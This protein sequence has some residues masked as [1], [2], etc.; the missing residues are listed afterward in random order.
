MVR[1]T[2]KDRKRRGVRAAQQ[3][4]TVAQVKSE[5]VPQASPA[6]DL[7]LPPVATGPPRAVPPPGQPPISPP[8]S[9]DPQLPPAPLSSEQEPV[10]PPAVAVGIPLPTA[11]SPAAG[12]TRLPAQTRSAA[13]CSATAPLP[14]DYHA[15]ATQDL[16]QRVVD[17]TRSASQRFYLVVLPEDGHPRLEQFTAVDP[18]LSRIQQLVAEAAEVSL[19]PFIG[20]FMPI[21]KGPNRFLKTPYGPLPLFGIPDPEELEVEEHGYIGPV[22]PEPLIPQ[23]PEP[24]KP[25]TAQP[26]QSPSQVAQPATPATLFPPPADDDHT[27]TMQGLG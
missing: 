10:Q 5:R 17:A 21:T 4:K 15:P 26:P 13:S 3:G 23:Q 18:L 11:S 19:F 1:E 20:N 8:P 16:V 27:P 22:V 7:P 12:P 9:C 25:V 6:P 14:P 24:P 2:D